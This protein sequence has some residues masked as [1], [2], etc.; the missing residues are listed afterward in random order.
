[1]REREVIRHLTL[2]LSPKKEIRFEE[3]D[4]NEID[5]IMGS[6]RLGDENFKL[7]HADLKRWWRVFKK[8]PDLPDRLSEVFSSK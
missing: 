7:F 2:E 6:W 8:Y 1:M 5:I 4:N 3:Y